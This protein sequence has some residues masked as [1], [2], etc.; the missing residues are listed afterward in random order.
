MRTVRT[1]PSALVHVDLQL[2]SDLQ[3]VPHGHFV[4]SHSTCDSFR[5]YWNIIV[6]VLNIHSI[7]KL[8][9]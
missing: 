2:I 8:A 6:N 3:L 5:E 4:P 1:F 9:L 7:I